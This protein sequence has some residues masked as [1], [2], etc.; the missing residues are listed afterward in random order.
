MSTVKEVIEKLKEYPGE[1]PVY[2]NF[3]GCF[4][5]LET[6][7]FDITNEDFDY[8]GEDDPELA[9]QKRLEIAVF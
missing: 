5:L 4:T 8:Y 1:L 6:A 3:E 9:K 7:Q 2:I